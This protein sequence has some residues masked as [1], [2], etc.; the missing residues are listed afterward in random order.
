MGSAGARARACVHRLNHVITRDTPARRKSDGPDFIQT[1]LDIE[2]LAEE[3]FSRY[4]GEQGIVIDGAAYAA[5]FFRREYCPDFRVMKLAGHLALA[6]NRRAAQEKGAPDAIRPLR[7]T[8]QEIML[9]ALLHDLGKQHEDCAPFIE[10]LKET[11]LRGDAGEEASR[12]KD[13]LLGIVRDVHCRKG[14][15]MI[16]RLHDAGR[17]EL[18]NP[19]I[20]TVARSHGDDFDANL[21]RKE[22]QGVWWAREINVVTIA[23]DYDAMTSD[24]PER[25]YKSKNLTPADAAGLLRKGVTSGRYEPRI[26]E[27]FIRDVLQ[28]E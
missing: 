14:P 11:D 12:R 10:L 15:C 23:D 6:V 26:A 1:D 13:Y 21:G 5:T 18:N 24:G 17:A 7:V 20:A 27:I 9:A 19:F 2:S 25:A 4:A 3:I 28:L 22:K 8:I 16:D